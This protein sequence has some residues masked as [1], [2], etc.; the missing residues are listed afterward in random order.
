MASGRSE[1]GDAANLFGIEFLSCPIP[2]RGVPTSTPNIL[3]SLKRITAALENGKHVAIHCRQGVGRSGLMAAGALINS[4]MDVGK[5]TELA[6]QARGV[7]VPE[8]AAQLAWLRNAEAFIP[9]SS[10]P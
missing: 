7:T 2:D 3:A 5:A 6:S 10:R 4:G 8:T 9:S 1:R